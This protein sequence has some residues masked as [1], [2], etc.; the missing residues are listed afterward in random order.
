M[1]KRIAYIFRHKLPQYHSIEALFETI[2]AEVAKTCEVEKITLPKSGASISSLL[3]NLRSVQLSNNHIYHITGDVNYMALKLAGNAVLTVHDVQSAL[4]GGALKRWLMKLLWFQW[5]AKRVK[6][7]T[8]ISEFSQGE[9]AAL[10][11]GEAHK[12]RVIH[13]PVG[14]EF[15][16]VAKDFNTLN[17][18]VLCMGTKPNKNLEAVFNSVAGLPC[19]LHI[20]GKLTT[21]QQDLLHQLGIAYTNSVSLSREA[22]VKAYADCDVLCFPSTYE[23]FGMPIIEAQ[24]TGRPVLT[25]NLG[26]MKEVAGSSACLV[27]P[28]DVGAI[29]AGLEQ[30]IADTDYRAGLIEKGFENV[31][32]FSLERIAAQYMDLY[33]EM[34]A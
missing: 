23:G 27:D 1:N 5:P 6:L 30:I 33:H 24:A 34:T 26:A 17:P 10:V 29:R 19:T 15:K 28:Y 8:V 20:V 25:S 13:N 11:P 32:R 4:Q 31:K 2:S 14:S 22:I 16:P 9:L 21:V 18:T 3:S 7:M 12:I